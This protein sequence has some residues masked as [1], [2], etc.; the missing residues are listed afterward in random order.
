MRFTHPE[1]LYA[2]L[3]VLVPVIVHLFNFRRTRKILFSNIAFLKNITIETKKQK[4]WK[5][6]LVLLLR[7]LTI[8]FATLAFAG[9][10]FPNRE[11]ASR[12]SGTSLI[13]L[14][15]SY[16]MKAEGT[17]GRLFDEARQQTA[18]LVDKSLKNERFSISSNNTKSG[19]ALLNQSEA[20]LT[21]EKIHLGSSRQL[22][23]SI[24]KKQQRTARKNKIGKYRTFL[25]SDFQKNQTDFQNTTFD[26]NS[27]YYFFPYKH[28]VL[29]NLFIDSCWFKRPD[30]LLGKQV[31]MNVRVRNASM[32]P[33]EKIS[34][35]LF[36]DGHQKA[37]AALNIPAEGYT[38]VPL[39]FVIEKK[40]WHQGEVKI[41]DFP[42]TF[43]DNLLFSFHV[44]SKVNVLE[45]REATNT[46]FDY[47]KTFYTSDPVF[48]FFSANVMA[49]NN[50][51]FS[52]YNVIVLNGLQSI[53]SGLSHLLANFITAGGRL[54]FIPPE[55]PENLADNAFL[56]ELDAGQ[57]ERPDTMSD[58]VIALKKTN[59]LFSNAIAEIPKNADFPIV[60][61][62]YPLRYS[63][64][65]RINTLVRLLNGDDF[66]CS[67]TIGS[68]KFYFLSV[69]LTDSYSNLTKHPLFSV[70]LYGV[71][72]Q[73][74]HSNRLYYTIGKD[75]SLLLD[76]NLLQNPDEALEIVLPEKQG[77]FIPRQQMQGD[78]LM[79]T[80]RNAITKQGFYQLTL[81]DTLYRLMAFNWNRKESEMNFYNR[82]ALDSILKK[83]EPLHYK[84]ANDNKAVLKEII[85][86]PHMTSRL[87][88]LF[89]IFALL[90]LLTESLIL[91]FWK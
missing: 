60:H 42:I 34:I 10:Y 78:K 85:N 69:P 22:L 6:L 67:K 30:L 15:N 76:R 48:R 29:H 4:K 79:I 72:T 65:N 91:R 40:G 18:M 37:L 62:H 88:K 73:G 84:V 44:I 12:S 5:H 14:D 31:Q 47:V 49:L 16:S 58:R 27:F 24:L 53:S 80:L 7:I 46:S 2:L 66:V 57:I 54:L 82:K 20:M 87:W 77:K 3:A 41:E 43:D 70:L 32:A 51:R 35:K 74:F 71:A 21:I 50:E 55:H 89:I 86:T 25:F 9:P 38:V 17:K 61:K 11:T 83:R 19:S 52:N 63:Y 39:G 56:K 33:V 64:K 23:S 28:K 45:I 8:V 90:M 75:E 81:N 26:T 59:P 36:V 13:Y 68:G 1:F